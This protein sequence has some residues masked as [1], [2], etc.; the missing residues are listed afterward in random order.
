MDVTNEIRKNHIIYGG[1]DY[2][3]SHRHASGRSLNYAAGPTIHKTCASERN[4]HSL[5]SQ[6]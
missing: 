6:V 5:H 3:A 4:Y 1:S 2:T